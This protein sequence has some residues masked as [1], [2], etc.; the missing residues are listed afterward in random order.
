MDDQ[1]SLCQLMSVKII[2]HNFDNMTS[3]KGSND[4]R[5]IPTYILEFLNG[6]QPPEVSAGPEP[7][8]PAR[9]LEIP[10]PTASQ[11]TLDINYSP[12]QAE[13]WRPAHPSYNARYAQVLKVEIFFKLH[14]F[15]MSSDV[16]FSSEAPKQQLMR[17][18][19]DFTS[20]NNQEL[21]IRKGEIVEASISHLKQ[22]P[23][24]L[25]LPLTHI[26]VSV[27]CPPTAAGQVEAVVEGQGP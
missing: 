19:Y 21:S 17:V 12:G 14:S 11:V 4:D 8:E 9:G 22:L 26:P 18:L 20:R 2:S 15:L 23:H 16:F 7:R 27:L 6:W 10:R 1:I 24:L 25:F 13:K 5:D 3:T